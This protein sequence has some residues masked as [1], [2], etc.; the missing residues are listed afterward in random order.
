MTTLDD[1]ERI[2]QAIDRLGRLISRLESRQTKLEHR[3]INL[4]QTAA[5]A[6][7]VV[8]ASLSFLLIILSHQVPKM[9][10]AIGEMNTRFE[11]VA[12]D[13]ARMERTVMQMNDHMAAFPEILA[14]VDHVHAGV[15]GMGEDVSALAGSLVTMDRDL[16]V[17]G[18]SIADMRQSFEI[19]E[20]NVGR[21]GLDVNQ[22]ST[23]ARIFNQFNPFQ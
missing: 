10:T 9:T 6:F 8:V 17:M 2:D 5:I 23:P 7:A 4:Y 18:T 20:V 11:R 14:N 1:N 19:M 13:M 22:L 16:A 12:I 15:A 3:L 21:M